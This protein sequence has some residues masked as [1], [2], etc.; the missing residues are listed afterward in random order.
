MASSAFKTCPTCQKLWA[1]TFKFCPEDGAPLADKVAAT[2]KTAVA[3]ARPN[4]RRSSRVL[5][6]APVT[7][8]Q[9]SPSTPAAIA[10]SH[11]ASR[12]EPRH[13]AP[14]KRPAQQPV[15]QDGH[16]VTETPAVNPRTAP[17]LLMT[18][19][20]SEDLIEA[21]M[22]RAE[23]RAASSEPKPEGGKRKKGG[24]S[25][26]EWFLAPIK[27]EEVD[28]K[29]GQVKVDPAKYERNTAIP[30]EK[31]RRFSLRRDDEE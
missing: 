19:A 20:V 15:S 30:E 12:E 7:A 11:E 29:T 18:P 14:R 24:F 26:T 1:A 16:T 9:T 6:I 27:A 23:E 8:A 3:M 28:A 31:R 13:T 5:D 21:T 4:A 2:P 10:A 22:K 25:E 17:T